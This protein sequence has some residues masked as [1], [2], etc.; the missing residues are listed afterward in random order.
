LRA[1]HSDVRNDWSVAGLATLAGMSRSAFAARFAA[2]VGCAPLSYLS[3]WRMAMA[4][5]ALSRGGKSLDRIAEE[6]GYDST[7]AFSTAFRR[8]VGCSP[9][10][11]A[12]A[13]RAATVAD[14]L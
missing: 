4:Q 3:R 14:R 10:A 6:T 5:D 9:G 7:S 12:R 2:T 11:F 8:R 13:R 1:M